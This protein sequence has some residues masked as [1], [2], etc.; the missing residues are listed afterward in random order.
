[1]DWMAAVARLVVAG[2]VI[3][4]VAVVAVEAAICGV[5]LAVQ[6]VLLGA[7]LCHVKSRAR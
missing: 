7:L 3:L 6:P 5:D 4:G 2:V 1:M